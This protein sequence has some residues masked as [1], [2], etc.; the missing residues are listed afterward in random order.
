MTSD[1]SLNGARA[2][3]ITPW[4]THQRKGPTD[5]RQPIKGTLFLDKGVADAVHSV[6]LCGSCERTAFVCLVFASRKNVIAVT[7][8]STF[9]MS[10]NAVSSGSDG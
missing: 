8:L 4:G 5:R 6:G 1:F 7:K 9:D 2:Y 10:L 3:K